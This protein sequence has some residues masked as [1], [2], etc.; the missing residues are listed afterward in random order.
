MTTVE[1]TV[2]PPAT[3]QGDHDRF[4]HIVPSDQ[5][6]DAMVYGIQIEALCGK[7]WIPSRDPESFPVCKGCATVMAEKLGHSS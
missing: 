3:E 7:R 4:A 1:P 6:V 2:A 5:L